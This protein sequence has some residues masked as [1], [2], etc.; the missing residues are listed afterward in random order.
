MTSTP[1]DSSGHALYAPPAPPAPARVKGSLIW[2]ILSVLIGWLVV[3]YP[4]VVFLFA[5][6]MNFTGCFFECSGDTN[7]VA[8]TLFAFGIVLFLLGPVL[9]GCGIRRPWTPLWKIG[10]ALVVPA[11]L[12]VAHLFLGGGI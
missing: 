7:P 3:A 1:P 5:A 12:L 4:A 8:G 10:I 11:V 6:S 2:A 9:I